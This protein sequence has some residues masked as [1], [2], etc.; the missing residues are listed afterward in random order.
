MS[1][2]RTYECWV[3]DF[4]CRADMV[5]KPEAEAVLAAQDEVIRRQK[6]KRCLGNARYCLVKV[7]YYDEARYRYGARRMWKWRQR[8][9]KLAKQFNSTAQ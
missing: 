5:S 2:L 4:G 6:Y 8:W 1:E 3:Y 9:L 7:W